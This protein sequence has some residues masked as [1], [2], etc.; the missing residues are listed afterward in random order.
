MR[1]R[2]HIYG[3]GGF[4]REVRSMLSD[5]SYGFAGYIDDKKSGTEIYG[6]A[7]WLLKS[8]VSQVVLAVGDSSTRKQMYGRISGGNFSYPSLVHPTVILQDKNSI[9]V[10]DGCILTAGCIFT[11]NIE[12]GAFTIINLNTTV[13]HDVCIGKFVSIMPSVN[14]G[15]GVV[16]EDEVYLGTNATI[17][18]FLRIGKGAVVGA[19]AVVTKDVPPGVT[20]KGVPA[21]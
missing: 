8:D 1:N 20:V 9:S 16:L 3:A 12:I 17:L 10:N 19:G 11:C 7:E 13:G 2:L 4:G 15:G 6:N 5:T 14:V 21:R 18:P